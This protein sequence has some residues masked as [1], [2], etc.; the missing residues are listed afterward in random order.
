MFSDKSIFESNFIQDWLDSKKELTPISVTSI[1]DHKHQQDVTRQAKH[2]N[3]EAGK[4]SLKDKT[5]NTRQRRNDE[6]ETTTNMITPES[7]A[8]GGNDTAD[9]APV[10]D[11]VIPLP[12]GPKRRVSRGE[13]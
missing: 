13:S 2:R 9:T 5:K 3:K 11:K 4:F 8:S 12:K 1:D 10:S 7:L 6:L